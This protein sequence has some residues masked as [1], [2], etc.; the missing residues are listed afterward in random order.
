MIPT[1]KRQCLGES[2]ARAE[3]FL[4]FSCLL[5]QFS[6]TVQVNNIVD[7]TEGDPSFIEAKKKAE[8]ITRF[9]YPGFGLD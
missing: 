7:L 2:L 1:G 8:N 4:F 5:H 9:L 3:L 6:F